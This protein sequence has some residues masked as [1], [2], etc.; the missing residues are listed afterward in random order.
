MKLY[1][2]AS[3][4]YSVL[5]SRLRQGKMQIIKSERKPDLMKK[6]ESGLLQTLDVLDLIPSWHYDRSISF[7]LEPIPLDIAKLYKGKHSFWKSG[8]ELFEHVIDIDDLA[9]EPFYYLAETPKKIE[10]LYE[11]QDWDSITGPN[12]P[13]IKQ[14]L[15]EIQ[16]MEKKEHYRWKGRKEM[17]RVCKPFRGK[18]KDY[19]KKVV[20]IHEK[21]PEDG[22][23]NKYAACVPHLMVYPGVMSIK[24][25]N[26]SKITLK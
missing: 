13:K 24:V 25:D 19:I 1:H 11:K 18:L 4:P 22:I 6:M 26:V 20:E 3:E 5:K 12:D 14:F 16:K 8:V 21:H 15:K 23:M 2:Y 9:A 17:L 7:F 10:F